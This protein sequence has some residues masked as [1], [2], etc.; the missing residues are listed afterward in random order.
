MEFLSKDFNHTNASYPVNL[1]L[2][3]RAA[4]AAGYDAR[5]TGN[6]VQAHLPFDPTAAFHEYRIDLLPGRVLFY[7]EGDG[8]PLARMDGPDV[9]TSPGHLVLQHWSNGNPLWSGGPPR[10]DAILEVQYVKAYFNSSEGARRRDWAARCKDPWARG[11]VCEIP[12][13]T[14][15]NTSAAGWFF[16]DGYNMTNNQ[17]VYG[18]SEG[19]NRLGGGAWCPVLGLLFFVIGRAMA[20]W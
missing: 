1:V 18:K 20:L 14:E 16:S 19:S 17:T 3:S 15:G 5:A 2:Q 4:A 13:R 10:E 9:P 11:A 12:E 8:S 7:A 6:F